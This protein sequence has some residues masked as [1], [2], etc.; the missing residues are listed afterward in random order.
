MRF[1]LVG[2][3]YISRVHLAALRQI[4]GAEAVV[5]A[6]R[7]REKAEARAAEFGV[8]DVSTDWKE[9]FGRADVDAALVCLPHK[10]HYPCV[11]DALSAGKHVLVEKPISITVPEADSMMAAARERGLTLMVAHM[12]RFDQRFVAMKQKIDEGGVGRVFL[13][14]SEWIGPKE[15]FDAIPWAGAADGGGGPLMGFGSH[16]IDLLHWMVGPIRGIRCLTNRL[17]CQSVGAED[18]AVA[19]LDF[20]SGAIGSLTYTWAAEIYGQQERLSIHGTD[21]SLTLLDDELL[22]TSEKAYGNRVPVP[23]DT[24]REHSTDI[25]EFGSELAI[26]S[27]EPFVQEI[28]HFIE[29]V[30]TGAEPTIGGEVARAAV[31][32]I[33][34]AYADAENAGETRDATG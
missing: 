31:A 22:H 24:S 26:A 2:C 5:L 9:A 4:A 23:V 8:S 12:K 30:Q 19:I 18:T 34:A 21:G 1:A 16:H 20:E 25:E 29:C 27:L 10:L 6:S 11:M 13:V 32:V 17:V 7:T 15:V 33:N 28:E 3:G 14:G